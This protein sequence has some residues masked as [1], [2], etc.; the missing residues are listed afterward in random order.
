[1]K[2]DFFSSAGELRGRECDPE[3]WGGLEGCSLGHAHF[4]DFAKQ[5]EKESGEL[6]RKIGGSQEK[7]FK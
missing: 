4:L 6:H 7:D 1:M 5:R 3:L 2:S